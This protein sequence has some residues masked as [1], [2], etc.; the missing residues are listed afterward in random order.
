MDSCCTAVRGLT[1]R[2]RRFS[3]IRADLEKI[4]KQGGL[5]SFAL[6]ASNKKTI[7]D[8]TNCI[9]DILDEVNLDVTLST[10]YNVQSVHAD[11]QGIQ[12]N[13]Q[14]GHSHLQ[15]IH[16]DVQGGVVRIQELQNETAGIRN[17]L[18]RRYEVAMVR[19]YRRWAPD[20]F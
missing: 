14:E 19:S 18:E 7:T 17:R 20:V 10:N 12:A 8:C 6:S 2:F 9:K 15:A 3:D 4:N 13:I 5:T 16:T 1:R 11:M